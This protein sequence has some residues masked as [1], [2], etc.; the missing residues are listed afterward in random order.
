MPSRTTTLTPNGFQS[1]SQSIDDA[2]ANMI[3]VGSRIG[4]FAS[5][6]CD[7]LQQICARY[8]PHE[9]VAPH[10]RQALD[11]IFFHRDHDFLQRRILG[12]R[13][14]IP[15]HH[16]G[17]L[18]AV[19]VNEVGCRCAGPAGNLSHRPRLR[20]VPIS[21]R[22]RKSP[23]ET[24]PTSFPAVSTTGSPLTWRRSMIFA[25]SRMVASGVTEI[26]DLVMI[27]GRAFR[28]SCSIL[29]RC[30]AQGRRNGRLELAICGLR[31]FDEDQTFAM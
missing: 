26:T 28:S 21:P 23:S 18:A 16:F 1:F 4:D 30:A 22:R 2:A 31:P 7:R 10:D 8:D 3:V 5:K 11:A 29:R 19:F 6:A 24:M 15:G 9:R 20:W 13:N 14:R 12:D 17:N 25:A 27:Y